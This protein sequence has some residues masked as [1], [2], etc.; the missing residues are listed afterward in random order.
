M[1]KLEASSKVVLKISLIVVSVST[2]MLP[3]VDTNLGPLPIFQ[4][5]GTLNILVVVIEEWKTQLGR[6]SK[7]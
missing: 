3:L 5:F 7:S 4:F 2:Y 6:T 1:K